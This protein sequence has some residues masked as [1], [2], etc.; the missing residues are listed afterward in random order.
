MH[1]Y[2]IV[3]KFSHIQHRVEMNASVHEVTKLLEEGVILACHITGA[4][5]RK[6]KQNE[7]ALSCRRFLSQVADYSTW[8]NILIVLSA[9]ETGSKLEFYKRK[10]LVTDS[11]PFFSS[12]FEILKTAK[13]FMN[14]WAA[15]NLICPAL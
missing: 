14:R 8:K 4:P 13:N 15:N 1:E 11:Q 6:R 9:N 3:Y 5:V 12:G 2:S 10:L 7:R